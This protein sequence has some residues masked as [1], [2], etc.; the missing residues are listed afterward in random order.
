MPPSKSWVKRRSC[1]AFCKVERVWEGPLELLSSSVLDGVR[2]LHT[3][4]DRAALK[5]R[6][7][8]I[9]NFKVS[10]RPMTSDVTSNNRSGPLETAVVGTLLKGH[11]HL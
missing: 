5:E 10:V 11:V 2:D 4:N 6:K 1:S 9:P 7:A 3:K 8:M